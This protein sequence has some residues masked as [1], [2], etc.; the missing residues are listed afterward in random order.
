[1]RNSG[2]IIPENKNAISRVKYFKEKPDKE[3]AIEYLEQGALWNGGVFA[4]KLGYILSI[5]KEHIGYANYADIY[6]N[7]GTL[8]KT[9][10]DYAVL[11]QEKD[12]SVMRFNGQ[13][14]DLGTWNTLTEAMDEQVIGKGIIA[15][16]CENVHIINEMNIP[17]L[18]VG[19]DNVVVS[20]SPEGILVADKERST[21]MKTYVDNISQPIMFAEKSW[22]KYRVLDV[23]K[24]S[25][26]IKVT[27]KP[28]QQMNYHSH[29]YRNEVWIITAGC[30]KTIVDGMEQEVT[31]GDVITMEAECRHTIIAKTELKLVEVQL[32]KEI[33]V[34]D[35]QKFSLE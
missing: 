26:T 2:D 32:G 7:Y 24:D 20:A 29:K 4:F 31:V 15:D 35:K 21:E 12:I 6:A 10:F 9:S 25:M 19:M 33:H 3:T 27:L 8:E 14:K 34:H 18:C 1:M 22:G 28:G 17:I 16:G 5:I 23:E 11:E 13:W 30:G